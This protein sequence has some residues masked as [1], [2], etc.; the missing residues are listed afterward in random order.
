MPID[1]E[2]PD[3]ALEI[4]DEAKKMLQDKIVSAG[5]AGVLSLIPGIGEAVIELMR[6]L[7]MQRLN[8][9]VRDMFQ[10]FTNRIREIGEDKVDR[11]WFRSEEFQTLLSDAFQQLNATH[12]RKKLEMLGTALANSGTP[13]FRDEERKDLFIRLV[14]E[15]T[16]QHVRVLVALAPIPVQHYDYPAINPVT[17]H[18]HAP[19]IRPRAEPPDEEIAQWLRWNRRTT[20]TPRNDDD[21]LALR[22]L[23]GF[24]LVEEKITSSID[25][26]RLSS[27]SSQAQAREVLRQFIKN[28]QN[29]KIESSFR[30]SPVG[31]AFLK[32]MGLPKE[33]TNQTRA[34]D[35]REGF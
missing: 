5:V 6:D 27:I 16:P 32:F 17:E 34:G 25:E 29:P 14:R 26:P 21:L 18:V 12:D 22:M 3:F 33:D 19:D 30:L 11:E 31:D 24:G 20:L 10:H 15:L 23:H 2:Q 4:D 7:A 13:G 9:R 35:Q 8:N 1:E 28:V